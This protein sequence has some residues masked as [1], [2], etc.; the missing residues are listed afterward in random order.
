[1]TAPS[2][3]WFYGDPVRDADLLTKQQ[4]ADYI[5]VSLRT[6]DKWIA[7]GRIEIKRTPGGHPRIRRASLVVDDSRP[8]KKV[9]QLPEAVCRG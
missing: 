9:A 8:R 7:Q 6:V 1:M 3:P 4:A 2:R 5:Q